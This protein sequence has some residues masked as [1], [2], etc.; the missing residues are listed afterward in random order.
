MLSVTL[1]VVML[2]VLMLGVVIPSVVAPIKCRG[3]TY[4]GCTKSGI[5]VESFYGRN[6]TVVI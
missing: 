3:T 1:N 6:F 5:F 2:V 4:D